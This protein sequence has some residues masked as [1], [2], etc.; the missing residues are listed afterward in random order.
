MIKNPQLVPDN[1][2]NNFFGPPCH[3][4]ECD[5]EGLADI[6]TQEQFDSGRRDE[7]CLWVREPGWYWTCTNCGNTDAL[8]LSTLN[9]FLERKQQQERPPVVD[10]DD[11]VSSVNTDPGPSASQ[12]GSTSG[13]VTQDDEA[14][15]F[16]CSLPEEVELLS[17]HTPRYVLDLLMTFDDTLSEEQLREQDHYLGFQE[18]T[19]GLST[20]KNMLNR[21]RLETGGLNSRGR[22]NGN[23]IA[24]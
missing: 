21:K 16:M 11:S 3:C 14:D 23:L 18:S 4:H 2:K 24:N 8:P 12:I 20:L 13:I 7:Y 22:H 10:L 1:W 9:E 15:S 19:S 6:F 17:G 5:H